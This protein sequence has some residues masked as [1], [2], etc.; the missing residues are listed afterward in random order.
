MKKIA[1]IQGQRILIEKRSKMVLSATG[2]LEGLKKMFNRI[3]KEDYFKQ[4]QNCPVRQGIKYNNDTVAFRILEGT[5]KNSMSYLSDLKKSSWYIS[6][7]YGLNFII[8][9]E[10]GGNYITLYETID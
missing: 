6:N 9:V 8:V 5:Q 10:E 3:S 2:S 7:Q 4:T 1:K